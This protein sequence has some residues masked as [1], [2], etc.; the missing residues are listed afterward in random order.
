MTDN[1]TAIVKDKVDSDGHDGAAIAAGENGSED[2][3]AGVSDDAKPTRRRGKNLRVTVSVRAVAVAA[4]V[5]G[6]VAALGVMTWLYLGSKQHLDDQ[7]RQ[8]SN[9]RRAEQVA[10]DYA[11]SAAV[12]D[13]K[14]LATW[15][16]DL[17][18][19][20]TPEL[21]DKLTKAAT[22]MEQILVPLEWNSTARPLVAKVR[23]DT[24]GT[25]VVD[26]FV[27]VLTKTVQAPDGLQSTAT[28]SVTI[29]SNHDW[30]ISDVGG[31]GDVVGNK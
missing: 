24:N 31:I 28:Y 20:T 27:S 7:A 14:D 13:F 29:D 3:K 17:V 1:G 6:L 19:G 15:K 10:L 8:A 18:K 5:V 12:M 30:L 26:A 9:S 11:V 21:K 25:Y 22:S 23:S 4:M 16:T 2:P